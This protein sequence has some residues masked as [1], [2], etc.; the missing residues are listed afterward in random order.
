MIIERFRELDRA[1]TDSLTR[2]LYL[3]KAKNI[4]KNEDSPRI[5]FSSLPYNFVLSN[6]ISL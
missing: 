2:V 4:F 5:I 6:D 1:S 3:K